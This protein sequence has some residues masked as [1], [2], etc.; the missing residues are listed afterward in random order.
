MSPP[1]G[2]HTVTP[3]LYVKDTK[4]AI[5]FYA[6]AFAAKPL[7][8]LPGP[9]GKIEHAEIQIGNGS[10]M[11]ADERP[12][13]PGSANKPLGPSAIHLYVGDVDA[14]FARAIAAGAKEV[15]APADMP[16]G[17]RFAMITDPAGHTWSIATP[18]VEPD[19]KPAAQP[20]AEPKEDG[21]K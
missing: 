12:E 1:K 19:S 5:L 18:M 16:W 7:M 17:H 10:V 14:V 11:I 2:F 3:Y 8:V 13:P 20:P 6:K 15:R 4:A 9:D 21:F